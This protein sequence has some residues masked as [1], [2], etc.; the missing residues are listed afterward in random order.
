MIFEPIHRPFIQLVLH[1]NYSIDPQSVRELAVRIVASLQSGWIIVRYQSL[2]NHE[3]A[4]SK[5]VLRRDLT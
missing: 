3:K 4:E 1:A 2:R 5:M